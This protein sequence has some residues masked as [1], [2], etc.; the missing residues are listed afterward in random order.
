MG[1][2]LRQYYQLV[3]P[4]ILYTNVLTAFAGYLFATQWHVDW[5]LLAYLVIG[6]G[7]VIA[8]ACV[9]NNYIDRGIDAKMARTQKRALANGTISAQQALWY[10]TMLGVTGFA[11][12]ILGTTMLVTMIGLVA[13]IDYVVLYGWT[14]RHSVHGTLI[15]TVSGGASLVAGY[16]AGTG[17]LDWVAAG[18][19][20]LMLGWQMPHFY[21]IA[22]R[23]HDDYQRAGLAML[24]VVKG[25]KRTKLEMLLYSVVFLATA[26]ALSF[27]GPAGWSFAIFMIA[28]G[29]WWL[30]LILQGF[31]TDDDII[32]AKKVFGFSL[33]IILVMPIAI[34]VATLLP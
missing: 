27:I 18:L 14:K 8:S 33:I 9:F 22:I 7:L 11:I 34:S 28:I 16:A 23:R 32:W 17:R 2:K 6:I 13:F 19:F 10:A 4:G 29:G 12:L 1:S 24:P 3:K 15:G 20:L 5:L 31:S 30:G 25:L 26:A 21:A